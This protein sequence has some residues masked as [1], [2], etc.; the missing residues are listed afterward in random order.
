MQSEMLEEQEYAH[1]QINQLWNTLARA[2]ATLFSAKNPEDFQS[3]GMKCREC[4]L[5]LAQ[6]LGQAEMV[7]EGK[8][9]P[10]RGNFID[11]CELIA[12]HIAVGGR[13]QQLRSYLK[14][15]SKSTWQ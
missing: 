7:P 15:I 14:A 13:N 2:R 12:N 9:L 5:L 11:W 4:L 1:D 6:R 3:V 10:Q 8:K